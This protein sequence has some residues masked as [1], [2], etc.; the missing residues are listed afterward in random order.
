MR[1]ALAPDG[2]ELI[3]RLSAWGL[4]YREIEDIDGEPYVKITYVRKLISDIPT[5]A[6]VSEPKEQHCPNC[7]ARIMSCD[8]EGS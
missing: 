1:D 7:G 2:D 6:F 4:H 8:E 5:Y 3:S